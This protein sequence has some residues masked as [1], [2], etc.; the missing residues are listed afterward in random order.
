MGRIPATQQA[1][2]CVQRVLLGDAHNL[3]RPGKR[4]LSSLSAFL[5][6][7]VFGMPSAVAVWQ[8]LQ[9]IALVVVGP[10][11]SVRDASTVLAFCLRA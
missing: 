6:Q 9:G 10:V 5:Q 1:P 11:R 4:M 7:T 3:H 2:G 8:S